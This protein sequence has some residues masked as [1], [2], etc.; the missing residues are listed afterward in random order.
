MTKA[1]RIE[2]FPQYYVTDTGDVYSRQT[3]CN[4]NGR[5]KKLKQIIHKGYAQVFLCNKT[6]PVNQRVHRLVAEAFI[7]NPDNKPFINH[8]NGIRDDNRVENLEWCTQKE[9]L[10]HA[11]H[12]LNNK[13][14]FAKK[15]GKEHPKSKPVQQI[16]DGVVIAVYDGT[17]DAERKTNIKHQKISACCNKKTKYAEGF[18]WKYIES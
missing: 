6:R 16:K 8:I 4:K 5:I 18:E 11:Y 9:N 14:T 7:P 17:M 15:Y 1:L 12:V 2:K 3:Y 10:I 13:G